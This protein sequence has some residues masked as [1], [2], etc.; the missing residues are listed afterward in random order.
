M[1]TLDILN[2]QLKALEIK[3]GELYSVMCVSE[4]EGDQGTLSKYADKRH[5][6]LVQIDKTEELIKEIKDE[7][8]MTLADLEEVICKSEVKKLFPNNVNN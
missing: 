1:K 7:E 4:E 8:D 5:N 3:E 6:V 2:K